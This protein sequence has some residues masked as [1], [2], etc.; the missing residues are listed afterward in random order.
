MKNIITIT[1]LLAMATVANAEL[2]AHVWDN[3]PQTSVSGKAPVT[4][5]VNDNPLNW[6]PGELWSLALTVGSDVFTSGTTPFTLLSLEK[7]GNQTFSGL[8]GIT[9]QNGKLTMPLFGKN[10]EVAETPVSTVATVN[11]DKSKHKS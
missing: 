11:C 10:S 5:S 6:A 3:V 2:V 4:W 9:V 8:S 7:P 1:S